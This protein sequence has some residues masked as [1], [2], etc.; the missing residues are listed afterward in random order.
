MVELFVQQ[1]ALVMGTQ[2]GAS[3]PSARQS[4]ETVPARKLA[5]ISGNPFVKL[6]EL[7]VGN[8]ANAAVIAPS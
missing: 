5:A 7:T 3:S 4:V 1:S 6:G 8:V 2:A